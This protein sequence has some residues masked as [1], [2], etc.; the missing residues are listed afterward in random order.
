MTKDKF[1]I[2][3]RP[4]KQYSV[5]RPNADRASA[6]TPTQK[7]AIEW[8]KGHGDD[9]PHIERVRDTSKGDRDKWRKG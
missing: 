7:E 4:D 9:K 8:A 5:K 1:Y 6:V 2:E 3:Q